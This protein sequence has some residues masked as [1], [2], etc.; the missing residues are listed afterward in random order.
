MFVVGG[1]D[2]QGNQIQI[3]SISEDAENARQMIEGGS[4]VYG[5]D[6]HDPGLVESEYKTSEAGTT[7]SKLI[8]NGHGMQVGDMY[9]NHA[10]DLYSTA[11]DV[12]GNEVSIDPPIA[13]QTE[14]QK[15]AFFKEANGVIRNTLKRDSEPTT[16]IAFDTQSI[17]DFA[18][19]QKMTVKLPSFGIFFEESYLIEKVT[20]QDM[21][22]KNFVARVEASK[23]NTYS[24][25][26]Q[27]SRDYTDYWKDF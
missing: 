3:N 6:H 24:F 15:V 17:V 19:G 20:I 11:I 18:P 27:R 2:E 5:V 25:S 14:G 10:L 13:G 7:A 22:G 1:F 16:I 23:R 9:W 8:V 26:S 4:G 12:N 21:D